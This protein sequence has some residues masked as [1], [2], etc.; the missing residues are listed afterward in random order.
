MKNSKLNLGGGSHWKKSGWDNLD[1]AFGY[2]INKELLENYEDQSISIIYTSHTIEHLHW[3]IVDRIFKEFKRVIKPDGILRIVVPDCDILSNILNNN[4][5][6]ILEKDN[7]FY[8]NEGLGKNYNTKE[9]VLELFGYDINGWRFLDNTMHVSFF[10]FSILNIMLKASGFENINRC[11]YAS[12]SLAEL[13][14][15]QMMDPNTGIIDSSVGFDNPA[16]K[17]ISIYIECS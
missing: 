4:R 12:S 6:D 16:T 9:I 15:T 10:N 1:L 3:N 17:S 2:D 8:Y 11:N 5:R 13:R 7:S 14:E